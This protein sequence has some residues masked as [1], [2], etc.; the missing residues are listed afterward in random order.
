M[1]SDW[2]KYFY[3][4]KALLKFCLKK[5]ALILNLFEGKICATN[6]D[7]HPEMGFKKW[8]R[9]FLREDQRDEIKQAEAQR[10]RFPFNQNF[11]IFSICS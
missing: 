7:P 11:E 1:A 3:F 6:R 5:L 4:I 9:D 8:L 10:K 2:Q